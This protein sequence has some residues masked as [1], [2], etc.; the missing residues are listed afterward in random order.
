MSYFNSLES[1]TNYIKTYKTKKVPAL[2]II[3]IDPALNQ[4]PYQNKNL[5]KNKIKIE[6]KTIITVIQNELD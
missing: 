3:I 2:F 5:S 6:K 1:W 4:Y